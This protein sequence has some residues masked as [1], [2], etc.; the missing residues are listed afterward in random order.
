MM[1]SQRGRKGK[2]LQHGGSL[3]A[4][5][6]A[7]IQRGYGLGSLFGSLARAVLP[8]FKQGA[9]TVGKAAVRTGFDIAKDVLAG[10]I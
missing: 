3:P 4:F 6:G 2:Q 9:K 5:H 8:L 1:S 7:R 10:Q